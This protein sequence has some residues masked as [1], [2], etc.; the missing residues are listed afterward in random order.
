M[1][2]EI[3]HANFGVNRTNG[4]LKLNINNR[5]RGSTCMMKYLNCPEYLIIK[6]ETEKE[7]MTSLQLLTLSLKSSSQFTDITENDYNTDT[8]IA[9]KI[10]ITKVEIHYMKTPVG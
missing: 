7:I 5:T 4:W 9:E 8:E 1:K 10:L 3:S 6:L 2:L